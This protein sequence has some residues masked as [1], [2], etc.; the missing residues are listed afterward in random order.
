MF[1]HISLRYSCTRLVQIHPS[2]KK[3]YG[4]DKAFSTLFDLMYVTLEMGVNVNKWLLA[5]LAL[6]FTHLKVVHKVDL[7]R[8]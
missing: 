6:Y 8:S 7:F 5:I 2:I 3:K 1:F 4:T